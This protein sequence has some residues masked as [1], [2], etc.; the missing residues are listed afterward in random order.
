MCKWY[1][2][3]CAQGQTLHV[4][5]TWISLVIIKHNAKSRELV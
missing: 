2:T 3:T 5:C 1:L 4:I